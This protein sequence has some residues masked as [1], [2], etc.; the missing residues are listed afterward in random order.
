M[1]STCPWTDRVWR[2]FRAD[3]L[4]RAFRDVLLT[5]RTFRGIG[6]ASWPSHETLADRAGCCVRTVQRAL[7]QAQQLGLVIWSERRVKAGW[8]WLRT[9]NRYWFTVPANAVLLGQR[10]P[11]SAPVTTGHLGGEG[12]NLRKKGAIQEMLRE[13]AALPDLLAIRR[14][15]FESSWRCE[16]LE[17]TRPSKRP[18]I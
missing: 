12:E 15:T 10:R 6:G 17:M 5:L 14:A 4:T 1:P 16:L 2:E 7:Q 8:R 9:S 18:P 11:R 3:N 13:A